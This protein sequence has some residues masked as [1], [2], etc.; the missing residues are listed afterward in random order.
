MAVCED[1]ILLGSDAMA[2]CNW[3][4]DFPKDHSASIFKGL[5]SENKKKEDSS[6]TSRPLKT[7]I[8]VSSQAIHSEHHFCR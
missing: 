6:R 8:V 5:R 4:L 7:E 1:L 2:L 3:G